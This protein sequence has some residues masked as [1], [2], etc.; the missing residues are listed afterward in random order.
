MS[1]SLKR[2]SHWHIVRVSLTDGLP[3]A[4]AIE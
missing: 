1:V 2:G 4:A 3:Q